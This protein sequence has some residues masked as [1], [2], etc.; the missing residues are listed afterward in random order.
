MSAGK[1][2]SFH[3]GEVP[4]F[5]GVDHKKERLQAILQTLALPFAAKD[6]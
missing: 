6:R 4:E 2:A 5:A 1:L 3:G